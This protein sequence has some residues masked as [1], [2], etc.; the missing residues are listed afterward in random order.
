MT[1]MQPAGSCLAI[2]LAAGEGTR[3]KSRLPKVLHPVAGRSM[4]GHVLSSVAQAGADEVAVVISSERPE[5]GEETLKLLPAARI[6][7]QHERRGTAHAVLAAKAALE[8]GCEHVLVAFADTPLV[9]PE[10]FAALRGALAGGAAVAVLGF[11]ADDPTGYGRLVERDGKLEAIVEHKDATPEQRGIRLCNAGL[12]ALAGRHA[13]SILEAIGDG[14]AQREFYLTDAVAV[15]RARGLEAVVLTAPESEVQGVNDRA[16][17]AAVEAEFQRRKRHATMLGGAT[18]IAPETVF[19]SFDTEL[20]RDVVV[21]PNV[22]FGPGVRVA[23][24]AVIHAFSHL[25][26][27]RVGEGASVGPYGRL[28]PGTNLA[29]KAKVGNFVEVKAADIGPGAKVNHL[30]YIGDATVGAAANIGAGTITCN[31][32]GFVKSKTTI[33]AN[34]FVGSNSSLVAPVTIGDGAYV[35]SGSVITSD[36]PPDALAIGRG[37]QVGKAGWAKVFRQ[38]AAA[39]KAA[40]KAA[41]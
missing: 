23:D 21:E 18:L 37:R 10:T 4:L 38:E 7:T 28:R 36:V 35:G 17:L 15:A 14:N 8:V 29:E 9:R 40:K 26:G 22:V 5:V 34:A 20:G 19:F 27:A 30:T 11:E 31:Y 33:G 32:D 1:E 3:M 39:R 25:E 2:V 12:M 6:A 24:G 13:L 16:Q 41:E